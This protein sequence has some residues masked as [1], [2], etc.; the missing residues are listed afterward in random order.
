MDQK[1]YLGPFTQYYNENEISFPKD[2]RKYPTELEA[3]IGLVQLSKYDRII[4]KQIENTKRYIK[5]FKNNNNIE[6]LPFIE[7]ATYSHFVALVENKQKWMEEYL[8][9]GVQLGHII[10]YTI[11]KIKS[12]NR[13]VKNTDHFIISQYYADHIINFPNYP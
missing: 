2:W 5:M 4:Q 7:G 12:Y 13:F 9:K 8:N 11:P 1:K 3:R 10:E 6:V